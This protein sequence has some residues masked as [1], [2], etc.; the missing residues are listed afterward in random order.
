MVDE[1][2]RR[3]GVLL[4]G[5]LSAGCVGG[6]TE[7]PTGTPRGQPTDPSLGES[8]PSSGGGDS[9]TRTEA[10]AVADRNASEPSSTDGT[11]RTATPRAASR[12]ARGV[13]E[14]NE[15]EHVQ[16]T[17]DAP[18]RVECDFV[19]RQGPPLDLFAFVEEE[20]RAYQQ[21]YRAR[22][23]VGTSAIHTTNVP[24]LGAT[25]DP[26]RYYFVVNN[27][28]WSRPL[29]K[30]QVPFD[31]LRG[32]SLFELDVTTRAPADDS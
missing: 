21:R 23:L 31:E 4:L 20:F 28:D 22:Y 7:T 29:P 19:V 3:F 13:L 5:S 27:T 10:T 17:L 9:A 30:P 6:D 12:T 26:G 14:E 2:R 32:Q 8:S 18:T 1:S 15:Y 16:L 24:R 25:L 11:E